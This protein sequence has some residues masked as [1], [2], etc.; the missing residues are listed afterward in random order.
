MKAKKLLSLLIALMLVLCC[1]CGQQAPAEPAEPEALTVTVDGEEITLNVPVE[2]TGLA[3]P[4]FT[5]EVDGQTVDQ[6]LMSG[7]SMYTVDIMLNGE[8]TNLYGYR[9]IDIFE[10]L[11][12]E[13]DYSTVTVTSDDRS[14][15]TAT[16]AQ[17]ESEVAMVAIY[18]NGERFNPIAC[19]AISYP[20]FVVCEGEAPIYIE[21]ISTFTFG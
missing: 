12:F 2:K 17:A 6:D 13:K 20:S 14:T 9:M 4:S 15:V 18:I 1:A 8:V 19:Q 10:A 21:T 5:F 3:V 16:K 7:Y 11:G